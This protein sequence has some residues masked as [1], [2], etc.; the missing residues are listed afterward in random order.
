MNKA[1][2]SKSEARQRIVETAERLFY[3]EGV[4]AVGI[5]R[6]IADAEVAK[7]S[8]YNHFPSK[9]D[10]I[11]A[12]LQYREEKFDSMFENW[13]SHH[14][15]K[16]T[17]RLEAFFAALKDWFESPGFRGCMFINARVELADAKHPASKFSA[18][19]K[20][21][22]HQMLQ[23]IIEESVGMKSAKTVAPAISLLVE[24]AIV[25]AVMAQSSQPADVAR[26][27]ALALVTK[28]KRK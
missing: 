25:T 3:A 27:A 6:I 4:R 2:A 15:S 26:E 13:I 28:A 22:F 20:E 21:R 16:G 18:Q 8:L 24:G 14:V 11:L 19:H 10:L 12:V 5:D 7:M 1:R 23:T 9:D 17:D